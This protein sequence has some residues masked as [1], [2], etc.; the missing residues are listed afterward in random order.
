MKKPALEVD[1]RPRVR[2]SLRGVAFAGSGGP[3]DALAK[4]LTEQGVSAAQEGS[5]D[6][7]AKL[8]GLGRKRRSR[9]ASDIERK[10]NQNGPETNLG[11]LGAAIS[12]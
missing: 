12:K 10:R 4:T 2:P 6:V 1:F 7:P 8:L 3:R 9:L 11:A 5:G